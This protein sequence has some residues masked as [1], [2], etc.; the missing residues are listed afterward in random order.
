MNQ[1]LN[2]PRSVFPM[3]GGVGLCVHVCVRTS[4]CVV[5]SVAQAAHSEA[6]AACEK[7]S[8]LK[9]SIARSEPEVCLSL[10]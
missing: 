2:T 9:G 7:V 5:S 1:A 6:P 10:V 3:C 4:V 8:V